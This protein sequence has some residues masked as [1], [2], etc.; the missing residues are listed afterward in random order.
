MKSQREL[1][2]HTDDIISKDAPMEN[3]R[4]FPRDILPNVMGVN[5]ERYPSNAIRTTK[6]NM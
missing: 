3:P 6:Y 2:S 1:I 4:T 5:R